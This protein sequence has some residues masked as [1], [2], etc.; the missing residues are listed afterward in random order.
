MKKIYEG[1]ERVIAFL[2]PPLN[3]LDGYLIQSHFAELYYRQ[4]TYNYT[5]EQMKTLYQFESKSA[6][7]D[8]FEAFF[9][10]PWFRRVWIVQEAVFAYQ[11]IIFYGDVCLD[12]KYMARAV[13]VIYDK[14]LLDKFQSKDSK[15][16]SQQRWNS[17]S[18]LHN[19]DSMLELRKDV[20]YEEPFTL[21]RVLEMTTHCGSTDPRN[22]VYALLNLTWRVYF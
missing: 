2:V 7:W 19:V 20:R 12:W 3:N 5:A 18:G 6:Q 15:V 22:K 13:N 11:L 21:A 17:K 1:A 8:A 4:E 9:V 16:F 10:N 14:I